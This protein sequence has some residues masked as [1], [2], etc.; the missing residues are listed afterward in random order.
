MPHIKRLVRLYCETG[1]IT[2]NVRTQYEYPR[3]YGVEDVALLAQLAD[4]YGH[5]NGRALAVVCREMYE[6]YG[7]GRF[8]RLKDISPAHI[9][10][11][12]KTE[13]FRTHAKHYTKTK[14]VSVPIGERR[15][16][17]PDGKTGHV[18]V[19]SVCQGDRDGEKGVYHINLVDE[20]T[21]YQML[22]CVEGISEEIPASGS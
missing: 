14:S 13:V 10:R 19:D 4:V 5:P 9:Y 15:K 7:D 18:R 3:K 21:Q 16:P 6:K 17:C 1:Y 2:P 11:L 20:V 8:V 12:K 22:A